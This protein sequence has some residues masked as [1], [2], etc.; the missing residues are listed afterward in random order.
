MITRSHHSR[1][2]LIVQ[3]RLLLLLLRVLELLELLLLMLLLHRSELAVRCRI[4]SGTPSHEIG[5]RG[6]HSSVLINAH[7]EF[8]KTNE[9]IKQFF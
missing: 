6:S 7:L 2:I 4:R 5:S 3:L 9:F 8:L 1:I